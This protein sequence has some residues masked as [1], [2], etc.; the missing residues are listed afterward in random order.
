MRIQQTIK[1]TAKP[2]EKYLDIH[3]RLETTHPNL[4]LKTN[5]RT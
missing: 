1:Q 5:Q 4:N 2:T 3:G